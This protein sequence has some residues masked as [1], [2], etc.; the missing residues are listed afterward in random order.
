MATR[1]MDSPI[2]GLRLHS[3]A[4]LITAI[5]FGATPRGRRRLMRFLT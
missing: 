2:G 5:D 3:S 4:G 1:W